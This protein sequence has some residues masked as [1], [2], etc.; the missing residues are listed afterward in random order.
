MTVVDEI[1]RF[2]F[3]FVIK[4]ANT[5]SVISALSQLFSIFG[6]PLAIHSDRGSVFESSEFKSLVDRWNVY[7]MRTTPKNSAGTGQ[8]EKLN[9]LIWKTMELRLKQIHKPADP[10]TK[11]FRKLCAIIDA[12]RREQSV[13]KVLTTTCSDSQD[14]HRWTRTI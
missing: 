13:S 9:E 8:C 2:P 5:I 14:A 4:E 10:G 12:C 6:Y 3:A 1:S 7:K 11:R